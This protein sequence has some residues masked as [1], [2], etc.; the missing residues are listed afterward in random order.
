MKSNESFMAAMAYALIMPTTSPCV[1]FHTLALPG[2]P[3]KKERRKRRKFQK[4][5]RRINRKK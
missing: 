5:A 3:G 4:L 1:G 2:E